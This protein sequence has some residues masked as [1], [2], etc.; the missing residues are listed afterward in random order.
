[1]AKEIKIFDH[2]AKPFGCLSNNYSNYIKGDKQL[3]P[4]IQTLKFGTGKP[5]RT[6]T[7]YI[8]ASLL[9]DETNKQIV[10][11]ATYPKDPKTEYVKE[12]KTEKGNKIKQAIQEALKNMF[13]QNTELVK[14]L[15]ST[16]TGK[17]FYVSKTNDTFL[18]IDEHGNGNN[19]YGVLLEQER[20]RLKADSIKQQKQKN[21]ENEKNIMYDTYL[22][23]KG[24]KDAIKK[25]NDLRR[26]IGRSSKQIVDEFGR[27]TLANGLLPREKFFTSFPSH[28]DP[29]VV[30]YIKDPE[31]MVHLIRKEFL[32]K[33]QEEKLREKKKQIFNMYAD[34]LLQKK[35]V[36][37]EDYET[38][39][40]QQFSGEKFN[41]QA[42]NLEDR[43]YDLYNK[44]MLSE[45]LSTNI[46]NRFKDYYIPTDQEI[47]D[48]KK[49]D[50]SLLKKSVFKEQYEDVSSNTNPIYILSSD[51][52][53]H[54][55]YKKNTAYVCFSPDNPCKNIIKINGFTYLTVNHYIIEKLMVQLGVTDAH[56]Y[57]LNPATKKFR[58]LP[59][60]IKDYE[61]F[62]TEYYKKNL[63]QYAKKGLDVKFSNRVMQDYLLA[64]GDSKLIYNDRNDSI[65]GS[66]SDNNGDNEVGMY[67]M[68]LR[69]E[70]VE[71]RNKEEFKLLTTA[72]IT[73]VLNNNAFMKDWVIQ[74]VKDSCRTIVI[75][76]DYVREKFD[77][78]VILSADFV[79]AV[80]D[81]IY[82]PCSQIYG[83]V[84]QIHASADEYFINIVK[85]CAGM[86]SASLEIIDVLWKR[87]AV[88]IYYLIIHLKDS[89]VK[90]QDISSEIGHVQ[91]L[92]SQKI[93]CENIVL[94][95]YENCIIVALVN[96][97]I[98]IFYFNIKNSNA[99]PIVTN[100][101]VQTA[102]SII[103][104][105]IIPNKLIKPKQ[106]D[107]EVLE[108]LTAPKQDDEEVLEDLTAP[109]Q[110]DEKE[111]DKDLTVS[112]IEY[113][114]DDYLDKLLKGEGEEEGEGDLTFVPSDEDDED[115]EDDEE[116]FDSDSE[117][118]DGSNFSPKSDKIA[119]IV[120]YLKEFEDIQTD[121]IE[122]LATYIE[123]AVT[124]IKHESKLIP[125][126][127][128]RNRVNF[129]AGH[130]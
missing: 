88:I 94:D 61:E 107:E 68:K 13:D 50:A 46:D 54:K 17:I 130:K 44:G 87:I 24:L 47:T 62:K 15:L 96:L 114:P 101:E 109:K 41:N 8:Y 70:F 21:I 126:Q 18:G 32:P 4:V 108:D 95:N 12:A 56:S 9:K 59:D 1:M 124:I 16:G 72:D 111:V 60:I 112:K 93:T 77:T 25:G 51:D 106:D 28:L 110:D 128:K 121:N 117:R 113:D 97:I 37:L 14:L 123:E 118:S 45:R 116:K 90:I 26:Y 2:R 98:G 120:D 83:A 23:Q 6:L 57:I 43:L 105:S 34:Y 52:L 119:R 42:Y 75:M 89:G 31:N 49:Y 64:T 38:A 22:A 48:T 63:I 5:C 100:V 76:N 33:L 20:N 129:F 55:R 36:R 29:N 104:E 3:V 30:L 80:L 53:E 71:K 11:S 102:A 66:G 125:E 73:W 35:G 122:Q 74:R 81:N 69:S 10:C 65:L 103:L 78:K 7:N 84:D 39:K 91:V 67:L 79:K 99:K 115:D 92:K 127:I 86:E 19:L 40:N 27:E 82:H 58:N 85:N